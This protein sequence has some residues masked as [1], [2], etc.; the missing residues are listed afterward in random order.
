MTR[1]ITRRAALGIA[2]TTALAGC[3]GPPTAA[4]TPSAT[5]RSTTTTPP[6]TTT[7][8]TT[9]TPGG[10]AVEVVRA[11][12]GRPEVAL[13]FH[14]AGPLD[15]TRQVLKLL[16]QHDA[17][18][19]VFAVG[20][21]LQATPDG[22]RM[23]RDG[24]HELGN[25]TWSHPDLESYQPGPM[26]TEIERCRDALSTVAGTPGT[27]FR[28]SQGQHAT[29]REL[30][31]AGKAGYARTLSYDVDSLDWTDPGAAAIRRAAGA[32]KAGSVVS[33]HLGH[34]GTVQALP[35]ILTDLAARGLTPVTATE[36]LR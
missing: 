9:A 35:G 16:A 3:S 30:A 1:R 24:G 13:T 10:P 21:W 8:T 17:K 4:P 23:V 14:G 36:L 18:I 26:L 11:S 22:A 33:M 28:Q 31:A 32:A 12:S 25:H 34:P 20:T 5:T 15:I 19:T 6:V 27:F 7:T 29:A 2:A